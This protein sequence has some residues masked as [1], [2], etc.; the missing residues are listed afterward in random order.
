MQEIIEIKTLV[1]ITKTN[2]RRLSQGTQLEVDQNKNFT[3]LMQCVE[4]KSIVSYQQSPQIDKLDIKGLGFGSSYKGKNNVWSF[5]I[6][7]DRSNVYLDDSG[8]KVGLLINDLHQ[9]PV[10][11]NLLETINIDIAIFDLKDEQF[12]NT[13]IR[14]L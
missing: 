1:D 9:V 10:I 4:L 14:A 6:E 3:T 2:A 7:T 8:N 5:T 11:K 12:K 13:I